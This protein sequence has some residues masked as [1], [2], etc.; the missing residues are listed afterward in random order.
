MRRR[1][2]R[3]GGSSENQGT[4][5]VLELDRF[6]RVDL[7]RWRELSRALDELNGQLYYGFEAQRSAYRSELIEA[8]QSAASA[9]M[10]C[11]NW[12]R[13]VAHRYSLDPLS[14]LGSLTGV[15]GRFNVGRDVPLDV[16]A[17]WPALYLAEDQETALREKF[18][19]SRENAPG[20]MTREEM[21]LL[22]KVSY[23]VVM[24]NAHLERVFDVT[25]LASMAPLCSLLAKFKMPE[26]VDA[27]RRRLHIDKRQI[28][29]VRTAQQLQKVVMQSD[30]RKWPV[31]FDLPAPGQILG[32]LVLAAGFEAIRYASVKSG[33]Q[34]LAVFPQNLDS[35]ES[36][37]E[38][39][40]A[41][42]AETKRRRLDAESRESFLREC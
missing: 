19:L 33:E 3:G 5:G 32:G 37:V 4:R 1:S 41:A 34:C 39:A 10:V 15:G 18:G 24:V 38:L 2:G 8:I 29:K 26:A 6:T 12:C 20:G 40:D 25:D 36:Y 21:A 7:D 14:P 35:R 11:M 9:P 17:P 28:T 30:W 31:Q 22:P 27:A 13:V 23:S 16:R 42:P